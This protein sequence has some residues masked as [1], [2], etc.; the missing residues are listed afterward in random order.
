MSHRIEPFYFSGLPG[1]RLHFNQAVVD[2][3]AQGAQILGYQPHPAK[4]PVLWRSPTDPYRRG[5]SVRGGI[6]ICWPWFGDI[7][8]N[9]QSV[10]DCVKG[11]AIFHG[12]ART[13]NWQLQEQHLSSNFVSLTLVL[14]T[15]LGLTHWPHKARLTLKV[16]LS[17]QLELSLTNHNLGT[18]PLMISQA[19]HS[20][21]AVGDVEQVSIAELDGCGYIET[22]AGWEQRQ[23]QGALRIQGELDRIYQSTP[24][25]LVI[26]DKAWARCIQLQ[27]NNANSVILWNPSHIKSQNRIGLENNVWRNFLCVETAN[28]LDDALWL[29]PNASHQMQLK[30]KVLD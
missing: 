19:L 6:P 25:R 22:L 24:N 13:L 29:E 16:T 15:A 21:Y 17:D 18:Y 12:L 20:Y 26:Q 7:Q 14:D 9:P 27:S 2:I 23:Q 30:I 3:C 10:Q 8:R 11:E 4:P 5:T 1:W 28:V